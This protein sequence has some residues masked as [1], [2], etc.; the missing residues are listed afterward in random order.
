VDLGLDTSRHDNVSGR[1]HADAGRWVLFS[2]ILASAMAFIDSS[3]LNVALPALQAGLQASGAQLL[4]VV[5]G[6]L[7]ALAA[8]ILVGGSLGDEFGRKKV[9]M[10]GIGVFWLG[11]LACGLAPTADFLIAA[12]VVEGIGGALMIP[13]SLAIISSCFD[14]GRRG[15]AI[16]TW[17]SATT[18][19]T[20]AG[21]VLGG[22]LSNAG[23]W[24]GVFLINLPLGI[25]ALL[26]VYLKVPESRDEE[27]SK[28]IDFLGAGLAMLG[29][30]GLTYGFISA[31]TL[32]FG[33]PRIVGTLAGG[34]VALAAFVVVEARASHAMLPL[35]LFSSRTFSGTNLMTLFLYGALNAGGFFL[36]LNLVQAQGYS[37][38]IAGFTFLPS[39]LLLTALSRWSGK[40]ADR[41]GARLPLIVGPLLVGGAFVAMARVGVTRGP[42][43]YWTTFFPGIV[44]WGLGMGCTVAP[45]TSAVMGSVATHHAGTA[46]G[47]NN[48]VART[49]GA[50]AIAVMGAVALFTLANALQDRTAS[51]DL[52]A[53]A[54]AALQAEA[55]RLG[56]AEVPAQV[57][58]EN[59]GATKLAIKLAF[60]DAFRTVMA[61]CAGLA[62]LSAIMAALLVER[63]LKA[64]E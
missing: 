31:P 42:V 18:M 28:K 16:G 15:Q 9:F 49:A 39:A 12:R 29:L 4:W 26:V 8:L 44:A 45:L 27:S 14:V 47:V 1:V 2:T 46:S 36:S 58:A 7:L 10:T 38:A 62:W 51:I 3:A 33:N 25:V 57:A 56:G 21:P 13:G 34:A 17:S 24:R 11:S 43:D 50:L 32:G 37:L 60:V 53:G 41:Y 22:L 63:R 19:V 30:A 55:G 35:S 5:N 48:A 40:V 20:I 54:R 23:L 61:I 59:A 64:L 6:Y 52:S